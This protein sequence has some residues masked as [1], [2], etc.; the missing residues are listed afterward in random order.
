MEVSQE[1]GDTAV[2]T[3]N[4]SPADGY[5]IYFQ[6]GMTITAARGSGARHPTDRLIYLQ[7]GTPKPT[8][9]SDDQT[10]LVQYIEGFRIARLCW[11]TAIAQPIM[12]CFWASHTRTGIYTGTIRQGAGTHSYAFSYLIT[13]SNVFEY[14]TITIPGPTVGTWNNS[15]GVGLILTLSMTQGP[16]NTAPS[17]NSWLAGNYS[18]G[19]G[20]VNGVDTTLNAFRITG[21]AVLPG[22]QAPTAAQSPLIMRPYDQELVTCKRY[23]Y[24]LGEG[25]FT[26]N[27]LGTGHYFSAA[28]L[29]LPVQHPV[30]MRAAPTLGVTGG[31]SFFSVSRN[32]GS[33]VFNSF[34]SSALSPTSALIYSGGMAGTAGQAGWVFCNNAAAKV[35]FDARL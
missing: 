35:S 7:V 29:N 23:F 3:T 33:E 28:Q 14:K 19:P 24:V 18:A 8:V 11:G 30:Q 21:L 34:A 2:T 22:T 17:L 25:T 26:T 5:R 12:L 16:A 9:V 13:A 32:G 15:N 6:G 1:V 20:Q 10:V 27:T 4:S 31:A